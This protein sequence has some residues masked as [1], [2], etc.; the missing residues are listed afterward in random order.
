M[1]WF[2]HFSKCFLFF[3][4]KFDVVHCYQCVIIKNYYPGRW[5]TWL[6]G[7]WRT[8]LTA[9]HSVNCRTHLNIDISNA[10]CGPWRH[11]QDHSCLRAGC[12]NKHI[13][14]TLRTRIAC[15]FEGSSY[16]YVCMYI[17]VYVGRP[18]KNV[19]YIDVRVLWLSS[20]NHYYTCAR[21]QCVILIVMS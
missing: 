4:L 19:S 1:R 20:Y 3:I 9:R 13:I 7:R 8:Q 21:T 6:A 2:I 11:I 17:Y 5:I 18:F 14:A 15:A 16:I 12:I 10:H